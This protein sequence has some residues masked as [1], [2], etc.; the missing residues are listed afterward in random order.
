MLPTPEEKHKIQ[1]AAISNPEL[2]LGSAEQFLMML[3]SISEL[4]AR[5]KLWI[6]KLDYEN[7]EKVRAQIKVRLGGSFLFDKGFRFVIQSYGQTGM[8]Y[9]FVGTYLSPEEKLL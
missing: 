8:L 6:F 9:S 3:S 4:P 1:E 7:L 5:L 2:P